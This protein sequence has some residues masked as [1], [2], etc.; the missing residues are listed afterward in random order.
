MSLAAQS[1]VPP[2]AAFALVLGANF[3]SAINPVLEGTAGADPAAQRLSVGNLI[4]RGA[5]VLLALAFLPWIG[6]LA[7]TL[8]P[9]PARAVADFHTAFNLVLACLFFPLLEP[10]AR[11]LRWWFPTRADPADPSTPIY[12][13]PAA[14]ETPIVALGAA[15]REALRLADALETMLQGA[16]KVIFAGDRKEVGEIKRLDDVLD[17]LNTAIRAYLTTLDPDALS[18]GDHRRLEEIMR[19]AMNI[20]LAGDVVEQN[21]VPHASKR[22]KRGLSFSKDDEAD[23]SVMIARLIANLRAAGS[24]FMTDDPRAAEM[25]AEEKPIFRDAE[26]S[27]TRAHFERLR[28]GGDAAEMST[29]HLDLLRDMKLVNGHIVAAAAYPVLERAGKLLPSRISSEALRE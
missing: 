23:L 11:F 27:A 4:N 8:S 14:R 22:F 24:L 16:R 5:G 20:E 28:S 10:Y 9:D 2:D 15:A 18:S 25:L 17:R 26:A 1:A 21:L 19:F 3:G 6:R 7:V 13:D 29:I 12:L